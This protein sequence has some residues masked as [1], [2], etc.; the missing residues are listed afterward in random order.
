VAR[1]AFGEREPTP[2]PIRH[3]RPLTAAAIGVAVLAAALSPPGRAVIDEVREV[4]GTE[5]V[6]GVQRARPALFSLPAA[7]RVLV[8]APSG[9][10]VVSANGSRRRLGDYDEAT[11]SPQG[12]F[13]GASKRHQLAAV[14]PKGEGRWTLS[15]PRVHYPRWS[16]SGFRIAYLSGSNLRLV[17][18]D[19][20][21]DRRIDSAQDVAPAWRPG[22]EH[23]LAYANRSGAVT[24]LATDENRT[25]WT[26]A[27]AAVNPAQ[28]EWSADATRLLVARRLP[29]GQFA[30]VVFDADGRRLQTL[31]STASSWTPRSLP[32]TTAWRSSVVLV[33]SA[34]YSSSLPTHSGSSRSS[35]EAVGG[36]TTSPGHRTGAGCCSAGQAPTGGSSFAQR[37]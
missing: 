23:V 17:A 25:S 9:A 36:S 24:L 16:P 3:R 27:G 5:K 14:T 18:G 20:T 35:S 32:A 22:A 1:S 29:G 34:S 15:R 7:G 31:A 26:A 30:L 12:L 6:V 11:W 4:V 10:W 8:S 19:G 28:L 33:S 2:W 37:T 21:G 13:V